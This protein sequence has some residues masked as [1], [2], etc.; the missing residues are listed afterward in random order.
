MQSVSRAY[1]GMSD[2]FRTL[3]VMA[4]MMATALEVQA[5]RLLYDF[6][7]NSPQTDLAIYNSSY[8]IVDG[9][10]FWRGRFSHYFGN[11]IAFETNATPTI[12]ATGGVVINQNGK[13]FFV[14]GLKPGDM[15]A[16]TYTGSGAEVCYEMTG[17]TARIGSVTQDKTV[18]SSGINY[19]IS[20]GGDLALSVKYG[21][22]IQ[23][24]LQRVVINTATVSE[25]L[26]MP[27][28]MATYYSTHPLDF[29]AITKAK[30]YI[31]TGFRNGKFSFRQVRYVPSYT[32]FLVVA[33]G[34]A[35]AVSMPVG[36]STFSLDNTVPENLFKGMITAG[37]IPSYHGCDLYIIGHDDQGTGIFQ[38]QPGFTCKQKKAY[39]VVP[40][41]E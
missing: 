39:L 10:K 7:E 36:R 23:T 34:G 11:K 37:P 40:M 5:V 35:N 18:I 28:G 41:D 4:M 29:S 20:I 33:E 38:V 19:R 3:L 6:T 27:Y 8:E 15:V 16:V 21:T 22:G 14:R 13:K 31:A 24:V 26:A 1:A 30:A 32:G 9:Y 2:V 12:K 25:G 17:G